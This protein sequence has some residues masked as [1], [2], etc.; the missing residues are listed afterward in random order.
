[1]A[2]AGRLFTAGR[3]ISR[4][5]DPERSLPLFDRAIAQEP[6]WT[7]T[8]IGSRRATRCTTL[9]RFEEALEAYEQSIRV[10]PEY[11]IGW[12]NKA[13]CL[14]SH[15]SLPGGRGGH[16]A[17]D[18]ASARTRLSAY[19]LMGALASAP[20]GEIEAATTALRCTRCACGKAKYQ[21]D[22]DEP[23][24]PLPDRLRVCP[25]RRPRRWPWS[26]CSRSGRGIDAVVAPNARLRDPDFLGL[27]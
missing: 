1:M 26:G 22:P 7:S 12:H 23:R 11:G 8:G 24:D 18:R 14:R 19:Q 16:G 10:E 2:I 15:G 21:A 13:N 25:A 17:C 4:M 20:R 5:G 6:A 9:G 3:L 27:T